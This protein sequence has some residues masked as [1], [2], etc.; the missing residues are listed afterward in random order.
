MHGCGDT[1]EP[2]SAQLTSEIAQN[3]DLI[4]SEMEPGGEV[5]NGI[6]PRPGIGGVIEEVEATEAG[7]Q[8]TTFDVIFCV[9]STCDEFVF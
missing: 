3:G 8:V 7:F 1:G 6:V 2:P 5:G 4:G 9:C